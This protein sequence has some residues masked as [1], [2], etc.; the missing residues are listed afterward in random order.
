MSARQLEFLVRMA[1]M[2]AP[3][4]A[5][6]AQRLRDAGLAA[7]STAVAKADPELVNYCFSVMDRIKGMDANPFLVSLR[8]QVERGRGLSM[9]QFQI[10]ARSVGENATALPDCE[11]V[12][13]KLAEFVEG[14]FAKKSADPTVPALLEL[15]KSV[16]TWRPVARKG[17]KVY[18][19]QQFLQS[20]SDQFSRRGTLS[21]RQL[22]ALKRVVLAYRA[23]I[24]D[25]EKK[26][27][28][29]GIGDLV[30]GRK[31]GGK[32]DG[33]DAE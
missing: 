33:A 14:G 7:G 29:L 15:L 13:A 6:C 24:P 28:S 3:Q 26:A 27:E 30:T 20:L 25:F 18:D 22:M 11:A 10:L 23:Q 32:G 21:P 17:K 12:Q 5:E 16:K 19:D 4:I 9:R 1:V 2:Y 8:D 31:A